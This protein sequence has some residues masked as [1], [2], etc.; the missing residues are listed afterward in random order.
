MTT[1]G[2]QQAW[3]AMLRRVPAPSQRNPRRKNRWLARLEPGTRGSRALTA[4]ASGM[5]GLVPRKQTIALEIAAQATP[6]GIRRSFLLRAPT[7]EAQIHL[8]AQVLAQYPQAR[9][10]PLVAADDPLLLRPQEAVTCVTLRFGAPSYLPLNCWER[11]SLEEEGSDPLLGVLAAL[12]TLPPRHRAVIQLALAPAPPTWSRRAQRLAQEHPLEEERFQRQALSRARMRSSQTIAHEFFLSGLGL[13]LL[14]VLLGAWLGTPLHALLPPWIWQA[15]STLLHGQLP[16]LSPWEWVQLGL[17][18]FLVLGLLGGSALLSA[19]LKK[20][21]GGWWKPTRI[22]DPELIRAKTARIAYR[23]R[24]RLYVIGPLPQHAHPG[25][26]RP[27]SRGRPDGVWPRLLDPC[28]WISLASVGTLRWQRALRLLHTRAWWNG[29]PGRLARLLHRGRQRAGAWGLL[30]RRRRRAARIRRRVIHRL[31]AALQ[32]YHLAAGNFFVPRRGLSWLARRRLLPTAS[33]AQVIGRPRGLFL[34]PEEVASLYHLVQHADL[35]H[36]PFLERHL[37]QTRPVPAVLATGSAGE[38]P[39]GINRHAGTRTPVF[40]PTDGFRSNLLALAGTGKGKS[41]LFALLARRLFADPTRR[42]VVLVDPH[43]DLAL[44]FLGCVPQARQDAVV[45]LN[46]A[47]TVN[48]PALNFLDMSAG[49]DPYKLA[50]VLVRIFRTWWA[51]DENKWGPQL[52]NTLEYCLLT[53]LM[54]NRARCLADPQHGPRRQCS[55][56][57]I[58][59]LLQNKSYRDQLLR[60]FRDPDIWAWWNGYFLRRETE[61]QQNAAASVITRISKFRASRIIRRILG[62][63][64]SSISL[65][66]IITNGHLLI[67]N[68]A[69]GIIGEDPSSLCGSMILGLLQVAIA[70]QAERAVGNRVPV[71]VFLDEMQKYTGVDLQAM[72]AELRKYGGTFALATQSL[73]YLDAVSRTLRPALLSNVDHLFAFDCSAQDAA[74]MAAEI[75]EGIEADDLLSLANYACYAKLTRAGVRLPVFSMD[76]LPPPIGDPALVTILQARS[77]QRFGTP[78]RV[79]DRLIRRQEPKDKGKGPSPSTSPHDA[80]G[81][82]DEASDQDESEGGHSA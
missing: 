41:S 23:A 76:L 37:G 67:L 54:V 51:G 3:R 75:G 72:I 46:L 64:V 33:S 36:L 43:G 26:A 13:L 27:A 1:P 71:Y 19:R 55:I 65:S 20:R 5:S 12:G 9:I 2:T 56:L 11:A 8:R 60:T 21:L 49:Q 58:V 16:Q 73:D 61:D 14:L 18:S 17:G 70:E 82:D 62:Q 48:P 74:S 6:M 34:T 4:L 59:P 45:Y 25:A 77:A 40:F 38:E 35:R 15:G 47:D 78:A 80:P 57:S 50:A 69:S 52:E 81:E 10:D 53:L 29:L 7:V 32:V 63:P 79:A 22:Y 28:W 66:E 31:V 24:L 39:I 44:T 68:T 42:S 30:L